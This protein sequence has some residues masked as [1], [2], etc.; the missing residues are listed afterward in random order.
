MN[1][2]SP[3]FDERQ[4]IRAIHNITREL[5]A[6][7]AQ[8]NDA[9]SACHAALEK[10]CELPIF[11]GAAILDEPNSQLID[12]S[13]EFS[14]ISKTFEIESHQK[15]LGT[16]V[17]SVSDEISEEIHSELELLARWLAFQEAINFSN[18][19]KELESDSFTSQESQ[20]KAQVTKMRQT[21][22]QSAHEIRTPLA[23]IWG[24]IQLLNETELNSEQLEYLSAIRD[25]AESALTILNNTLDFSKLEQHRLTLEILN[26]H[27]SDFLEEKI[28]A[29]ELKAQSKGLDLF[30]N[31]DSELPAVLKFDPTRV[32]QILSNLL[33]NAIKFTERGEI[34][35][36]IEKIDCDNRTCTTRFSI[37]DT[38]IGLSTSEQSRIFQPF[39]QA[40][41]STTRQ[42]GGT[43]LGL[44]ICKKLAQSMGGDITVQSELGIG[45]TFSFTADFEISEQNQE[46][47]FEPSLKKRRISVVGLS[48][49]GFQ[50]LK[51]KLEALG[52]QAKSA[53]SFKESEDAEVL[54]FAAKT[55]NEAEELTKQIP[56]AMRS[57]SILLLPISERRSENQLKSLGFSLF[58]SRSPKRELLQSAL[59]QILNSSE[60]KNT[61]EIK[62]L[63]CFTLLLVEDNE[64][65]QKFAAK[66]LERLGYRVLIAQS[67]KEAI[68]KL[69]ETTVDAVLMDVQLPEITGIDATRMIRDPQSSVRDHNVP[70]IALSAHDDERL[71]CLQAGMND[72]IS[73]PMRVSEL[74]AA[75][76]RVAK[77]SKKLNNNG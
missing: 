26:V 38:G 39:V 21:L 10:L 40:N 33:Q 22:A 69:S 32:A 49:F 56:S 3:T 12:S 19:N 13:G 27:L 73:K 23:G 24:M 71:N 70:I 17:V 2:T 60:S 8:S 58:L 36:S 54:I 18:K 74:N 57:H 62:G 6:Q 48:D 11:N 75:L 64:V 55:A 35:L 65:N 41:H 47:T 34:H 61:N 76:K 30:W 43:G 28:S 15:A 46:V 7:L 1:F 77:S 9:K 66:T 37:S 29:F 50:S 45:S 5:A 25:S 14:K 42:F 72:Y 20:L 68:A 63:T 44:A 51:T 31:L 67:C 52:C 4:L 53:N 16:L 59:L